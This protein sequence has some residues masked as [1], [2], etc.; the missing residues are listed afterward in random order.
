MKLPTG[1]QLRAARALAGLE[2]RQVAAK[3]KINP[4][5]LHRMEASEDKPTRGHAGNVEA[6][7]EVLRKAGVE[8]TNEPRGVRLIS[9]K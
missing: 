1:R 9:R 7:V 5:T 6:V 3:A 4:T 8:M 2:Q